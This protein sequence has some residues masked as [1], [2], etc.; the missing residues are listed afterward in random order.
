MSEEEYEVGEYHAYA[1]SRRLLATVAESIQ[2]AK[3]VTVGRSRRKEWVRDSSF[4][5]PNHI[6]KLLQSYLVKVRAP[7]SLSHRACS[8]RLSAVEELWHG[9]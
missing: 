6:L 4:D 8:D 1:F 7:V 2:Q 3:V 9:G 5:M